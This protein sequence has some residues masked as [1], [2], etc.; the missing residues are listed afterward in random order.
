MGGAAARGSA[1]GRRCPSRQR[2]PLQV[3]CA[4]PVT[5]CRE[6]LS[7]RDTVRA[8]LANAG[9]AN[10]ATGEQGYQDSVA[11]AEAVAKVGLWRQCG[12]GG[13]GGGR[14]G[15]LPLPLLAAA[16][17]GGLAGPARHHAAG[18]LPGPQAWATG[19]DPPREPGVA[20]KRPRAA[21]PRLPP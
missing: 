8:V 10:A 3:M 12:G 15:G 21:C 16:T 19:L 18:Q 13:Q 4:A 11:S 6:V 20:R 17:A 7:R 5:Y 1:A 9:Q 14:A 2:P